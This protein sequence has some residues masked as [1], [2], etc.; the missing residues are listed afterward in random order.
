[1]KE[2]PIIFSGEMVKAILEGR[3]TMTRRVVSGIQHSSNWQFEDW[4]DGLACFQWLGALRA[5]QEPGKR[6]Q[7]FKCPYGAP[8]DRLWVKETW[9]DNYACSRDTR[10]SILPLAHH[11]DLFIGGQDGEP[12]VYYKADGE[13][14]F[15]GERA[16]WQSPL[17]M[18]RWASRITLEVVS[19]KVERLQDITYNDLRSEGDPWLKE[20]RQWPTF[21]QENADLREWFRELWDSLNAKKPGCSWADN[22]WV[23]VIEFKPMEVVK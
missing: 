22:P 5:E 8:G 17:F 3:K 21:E 23:F 13:P 2:R 11:H 1:M 14:D 16:W 19:V 9:F 18:P 7:Y 12:T 4:F 10:S 20:L 6:R 15:D